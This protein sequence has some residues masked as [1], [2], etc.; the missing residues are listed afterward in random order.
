[1]VKKSKDD[2]FI[3]EKK[4][5][6]PGWYRLQGSWKVVLKKI[7]DNRLNQCLEKRFRQPECGG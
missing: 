6:N 7:K 3:K 2:S 1:M 4:R 5:T